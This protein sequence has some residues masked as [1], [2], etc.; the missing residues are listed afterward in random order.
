M[1]T[2]RQFIQT[3]AAASVIGASAVS[4]QTSGRDRLLAVPASGKLRVVLDTDT[5]NEIDDQ[6]ALAYTVLSPERISL[7]AIYA[8][9]FVNNRSTSA[10]QGME[11]SYEEIHRLLNFFSH[12]DKSIAF[13]GLGPLLWAER[14][15]R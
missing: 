1:P 2:R 8:A 14:P 6:Y 9:P 10:A 3:A 13:R 7:E 12:V 11:K 15:A 4:A 5:Y